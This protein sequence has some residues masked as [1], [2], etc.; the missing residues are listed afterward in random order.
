MYNK[1]KIGKMG[2][3]IVAKRYE[4][5][6]YKICQ[7]NFSTQFWEIDIIVSDKNYIIFVEVK[8]VTHTNFLHDYISHIKLK[9]VQVTASI[10]YD[11]NK[12]SRLMQFDFVFIKNKIIKEMIRDVAF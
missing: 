1:R 7:Q 10:Y 2:E 5:N 4:N 12:E 6:G 3:D 11:I 8:D 9:N